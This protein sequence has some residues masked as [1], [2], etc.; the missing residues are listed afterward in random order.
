MS[1]ISIAVFI[2]QVW[3]LIMMHLSVLELKVLL[4]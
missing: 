1:S 3:V 4:I 2:F